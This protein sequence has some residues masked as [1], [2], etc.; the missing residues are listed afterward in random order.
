VGKADAEHRQRVDEIVAAGG[1]RVSMDYYHAA[2]VFQHGEQVADIEKAQAFAR[3][4]VELDGRNRRAR[5]LAPAAEDRAPLDPGKPQKW[6]RQ[7]K[8]VDG[9]WILWQVDPGVTDEQ[10]AEWEVPPLAESRARAAEM[11]AR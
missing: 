10:R 4:A 8:K 5:W 7:F 11:N 6:G 1:A 3:R 2:M 9:R